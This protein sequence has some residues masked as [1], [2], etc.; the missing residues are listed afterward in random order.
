MIK[1]IIIHKAMVKRNLYEATVSVMP[2]K[3]MKASNDQIL[4]GLLI[5]HVKH[6]LRLQTVP[7]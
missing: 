2:Q 1:D 5:R 7:V 3:T 4:S 6:S